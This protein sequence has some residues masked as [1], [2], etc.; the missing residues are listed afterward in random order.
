MAFD[1]D[2]PP[3][4]PARKKARRVVPKKSKKVPQGMDLMRQKMQ[5]PKIAAMAAKMKSQFGETSVR[6]FDGLPEI[7]TVST[8]LIQLDAMIGK[9]GKERRGLPIG[10]YTEISGA[11]ASGKTVLALHLLGRLQAAGYSSGFVDVELALDAEFAEEM[12]VEYANLVHCRPKWGEQARDM[13]MLMAHNLDVMVFDSWGALYSIK[14]IQEPPKTKSGKIKEP[15]ATPAARTKLVNQTLI[16]A[17]EPMET[18]QFTVI[19]VNQ[20][21]DNF[22]GF[23][24]SPE[25]GTTGGNFLK[26]FQIIHIQV[27]KGM[28]QRIKK[29]DEVIGRYMHVKIKKSKIGPDGLWCYIPLFYK[30]GIS[31]EYHAI[32][33]GLETKVIK[34]KGQTLFFGPTEIGRGKLNAKAFLEENPDVFR[35]IYKELEKV[36]TVSPQEDPEDDDDVWEDDDLD[37]E[38]GD[39]DL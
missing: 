6:I 30:G 12:G 39:F 9:K 16:N 8:G 29:G 14:Q 22:G 11:N 17:I 28:K 13:A 31:C 27:S 26:H 24:F 3:K 7:K 25:K 20:I 15:K 2:A 19:A 23:S 33:Y 36:D 1:P 38:D 10:C 34:K 5:D 18:R 21:R 37:L 35:R 32:E 4:K